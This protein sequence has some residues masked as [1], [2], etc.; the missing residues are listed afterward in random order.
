MTSP[1]ASEKIR[2]QANS[3]RVVEDILSSQDF[4]KLAGVAQADLAKT[5]GIENEEGLKKISVLFPVDL[6]QELLSSHG[7][8]GIGRALAKWG[9]QNPKE[10]SSVLGRLVEERKRGIDAT[11]ESQAVSTAASKLKTKAEK[12][13]ESKADTKSNGKKLPWQK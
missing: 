6:I 9:T 5:L 11:A 3:L 2:A 7:K 8:E 10:M 12:A 13:K 4:N 1:E